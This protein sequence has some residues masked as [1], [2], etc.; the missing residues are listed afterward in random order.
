MMERKEQ[1]TKKDV[2][3]Y[4]TGNLCRCTG[5]DAIIDAGQSIDPMDYI[6][7]KTRFH[8][9]AISADLREIR[10]Q[11]LTLN[12]GLYRYFAPTSLA[13]ALDLVQNEKPQLIA[14][15]TDLGVQI[16]KGRNTNTVFLS[17]A[18][19]PEAQVLQDEG[20]FYSDW[21]FCDVGIHSTIFEGSSPEFADFIHLFASP[22]I[23][24]VGTLVGNV[25]NASPIAD[26]IGYLMMMEATIRLAGPNGQRDVPIV[27]FY[28][29]YKQLNMESR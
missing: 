1:P 3:N 27:D 9:D 12:D 11:A 16:N 13:D 18:L 29:G 28:L 23:K 25:A 10:Q 21:C 14:G 4:L 6:P 5:Y 24:N 8:T 17:L 15:S 26:A 22:Q 19:V 7:L 20:E 2:Q